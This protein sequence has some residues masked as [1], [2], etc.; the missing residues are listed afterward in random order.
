MLSTD[1]LYTML[2]TW[3][4]GSMYPLL[5]KEVEVEQYNSLYLSSHKNHHSAATLT[6]FVDF[7]GIL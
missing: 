4:C 2:A 6:V 3:L 5:A 7:G 1:V